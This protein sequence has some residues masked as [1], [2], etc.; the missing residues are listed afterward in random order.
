VKKNAKKLA[1]SL[2][3]KGYTL[4][5]GGTDN[6]LMLVDLRP[7]VPFLLVFHSLLISS[8]EN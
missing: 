8:A 1:D 6:H 5:S 2:V 7:Q 3:S 4:V